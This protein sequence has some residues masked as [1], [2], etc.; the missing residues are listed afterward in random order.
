[1]VYENDICVVL[2]LFQL[3]YGL[4]SLSQG[5]TTQFVV[6]KTL[7]VKPNYVSFYYSTY[8]VVA[9]CVAIYYYNFLCE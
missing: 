8:H 4:I 2:A 7:R 5:E 3:I 1:M 6:I 9:L